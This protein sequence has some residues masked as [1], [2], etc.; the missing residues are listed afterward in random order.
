E[1]VDQCGAALGVVDADAEPAAGVVGE[2]EAFAA[3]QHDGGPA[4]QAAQ[5]PAADLAG[6]PLL[7]VSVMDLVQPD[8]PDRPAERPER[9]HE[10]VLADPRAERRREEPD[11]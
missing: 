9:Q 11:Q 7:D 4:G 2:D 6:V 3:A 8:A 10:P 5:S 1:G